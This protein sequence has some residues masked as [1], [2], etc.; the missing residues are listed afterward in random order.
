MYLQ[1]LLKYTA[2]GHPEYQELNLAI[3]NFVAIVNQVNE[4][5]RRAEN[6]AKLFSIVKIVSFTTVHFDLLT[7]HKRV[8]RLDGELVVNSKVNFVYLFNDL[9]LFTRELNPPLDGKKYEA[10]Q[11]IP[12]AT[13]K[14]NDES[15]SLEDEFHFELIVDEKEV[16][17]IESTSKLRI[18]TWL[19]NLKEAIKE[20]GK[21]RDDTF[22]VK[23]AK[24]PTKRDSKGSHTN[25]PLKKTPSSRILLDKVRNK[26]LGPSVRKIAEQFENPSKKSGGSHLKKTNSEF[27]SGSDNAP[28]LTQFASAAHSYSA[29]LPSF[30][31]TL[32]EY[33]QLKEQ[34]DSEKEIKRQL[35][36]HLLELKSSTDNQIQDLTEKVQKMTL[37]IEQLKLLI[38]TQE[39]PVNL[40]VQFLF[41]LVDK[42]TEDNNALRL[43][44]NCANSSSDS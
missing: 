17:R 21:L 18:K 42:L 10:V 33:N 4:R 1:E 2:E 20:A 27:P 8:C 7:D 9:L 35:K 38:K 34:L 3:E 36:I 39:L 28:D 44:L 32:L 6:V 15:I 40:Q 5:V 22:D 12:L 26:S 19:K 43:Q 11:A 31:P 23:A 29:P 37:E 30:A 24:K 16:L 13:C 14:L 41:E 25:S